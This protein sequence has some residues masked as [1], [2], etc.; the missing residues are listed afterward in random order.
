MKILAIGDIVGERSVEKLRKELK[1]LQEKEGIFLTIANGENAAN[2][3]GLTRELFTEIL[4]SGVNVI[5]MG[6]HT[7][8][9]NE[10]Y[11]FIEDERIIRPANITKGMPGKGY[12]I[13]KK[14]NI[15][16]LVINLIGR[17]MMEG[18]YYSDNP[19]IVVNDILEET[20]KENIK[21][22]L[23]DFHAQS[24]GEKFNL[25]YYLDGKV[26]AI[27]GTHT[28][29]QT[30]DEI[31]MPKGTGFITD[32]GMTGANLSDLGCDIDNSIKR[33]LK[34]MPVGDIMSKNDIMI[35][36][37]IFDIDENTGKTVEIKRVHID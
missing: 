2:G 20:K 19:F 15:K 17:R 6:N 36:G 3:N 28:H 37:C 8:G 7:W 10:I 33:Y 23:V 32:I 16:I 11:D 9:N 25:G 30:A 24:T 21:I 27:Y 29:V 4:K 26:S 18:V 14:D 31:I 1:Q 5:T 35:N 34:D 12:T 22:I 13:Y